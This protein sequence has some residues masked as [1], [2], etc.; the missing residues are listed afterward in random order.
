V[1]DESPTEQESKALVLLRNDPVPVK[2][3]DKKKKAEVMCPKPHLR[4]S[5]LLSAPRRHQGVGSLLGLALS[6]G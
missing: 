2:T 1:G 4:A 3:A 5:L 6:L